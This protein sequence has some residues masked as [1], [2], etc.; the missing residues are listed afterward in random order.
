MLSTR[1][2]GCKGTVFLCYSKSMRFFFVAFLCF[3]GIYGYFCHWLRVHNGSIPPIMINGLSILIPSYNDSCDTLIRELHRQA[4]LISTLQFEIV[5]GDDGSTN[6]ETIARNLRSC[7]LEGCRY[8]RSDQNIGRSAIRNK[9]A[10]EA[11]FEWLLYLD[12]GIEPLSDRFIEQYIMADKEPVVAG[13]VAV[14]GKPTDETSL[15]YRYEKAAARRMTAS[16]RSQHPHK[17]FRT[18][19]FL[20]HHSVIMTHPLPEDFQSY[21]YE[22]VLFG[23]IMAEN[24]INIH[25]I[26]NPIVYNKYEENPIYINKVETS[27]ATLMDHKEKLAG[28]SPVLDTR[29]RLNRLN[30][31]WTVH[32]FHNLFGKQ[33]RHLLIS[34]KPP[35]FLLSLYKLLYYSDLEYNYS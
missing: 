21:G 25:H 10:M 22:D 18:C 29:N 8:F 16:K 4:S 31:W 27:L 30:L 9:L 14:K 23:K 5:I 24:H 35:L 32:L 11:R 34:R 6:P 19:N 17:S 3:F 33:L 7:E 1:N 15:R 20:I 12:S 13:G 2:S 28:Y 26:D